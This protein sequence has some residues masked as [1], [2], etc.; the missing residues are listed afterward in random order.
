MPQNSLNLI[1]VCWLSSDFR[2]LDEH[3][4]DDD[5]Y[6]LSMCWGI[7]LWLK[8]SALCHW[9]NCRLKLCGLNKGKIFHTPDWKTLCM[10]Y[11]FAV[12]CSCFCSWLSYQVSKHGNNPFSWNRFLSQRLQLNPTKRIVFI[13]DYATAALYTEL[14]KVRLLPFYV[15]N[16]PI[17]TLD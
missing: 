7:P 12:R 16:L 14:N 13:I 10:G 2:L 1:A 3:I 17:L 11:F 9:W 4:K 8:S 6:F 15:G 5:L